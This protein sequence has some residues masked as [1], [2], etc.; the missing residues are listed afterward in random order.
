MAFA[1]NYYV[2]AIYE[3]G[4]FVLLTVAERILYFS[5]FFLGLSMALQPLINTA[6]G[7]KDIC[8][9][10]AL[11][12][13]AGKIMMVIGLMISFVMVAVAPCSE[14]RLLRQYEGL[15]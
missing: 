4:V 13:E 7:E 2:L 9:I 11:A 3:D 14:V 12:Q 10:R 8:A 15:S 6:Q 1:L 5:T